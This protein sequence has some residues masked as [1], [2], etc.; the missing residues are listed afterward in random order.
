MNE[1]IVKQLNEILQEI[2][3][4]KI[5]ETTL[6]KTIAIGDIVKWEMNR[7]NEGG[8]VDKKSVQTLARIFDKFSAVFLEKGIN[9]DLCEAM[10]Q[11]ANNFR[12]LGN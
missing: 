2:S 6:A 11:V 10:N 3:G 8:V 4:T 12:K 1:E 7:I 9:P 5:D